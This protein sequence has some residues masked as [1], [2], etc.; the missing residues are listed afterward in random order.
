MVAARAMTGSLCGIISQS[1]DGVGWTAN[2]PEAL[3]GA[4]TR[5]RLGTDS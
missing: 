4:T 1:R 5:T 2:T 3:F